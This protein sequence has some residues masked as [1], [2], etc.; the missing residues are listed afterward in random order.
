MTDTRRRQAL[1][2]L[3][4][5]ALTPWLPAHAQERA[6]TPP[7]TEGPFYPQSFPANRDADLTRVA[8]RPGRAAGT[9][10]EFS[11]RLLDRKGRPLAGRAIEIWHCDEFGQYHHV[12]MPESSGDASFQ[13][14]GEAFEDAEGRFSFLTIKPPPYPGRTPHIHFTVRDGRRRV[15][16]SQAFFEGER[17]NERDFLYRGLGSGA[18]LVTMR[19]ESAGQGL[20][21]S[22]DVVLGG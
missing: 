12:G 2:S 8:G 21:G 11:G 19:L 4:A 15:L 18:K 9:P 7:L 5:L 17:A 20:R 16:T 3:G 22:L 14:W 6:A 13:G 10:L 1:A